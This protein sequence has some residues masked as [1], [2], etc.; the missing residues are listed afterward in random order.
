MRSTYLQASI[1]VYSSDGTESGMSILAVT[2]YEVQSHITSYLRL[3]VPCVVWHGGA[4]HALKG[5]ADLTRFV[6]EQLVIGLD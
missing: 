5:A 6:Q 3:K 1:R 4:E 2:Q